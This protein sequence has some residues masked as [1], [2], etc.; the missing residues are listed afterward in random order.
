MTLRALIISYKRGKRGRGGGGR[1]GKYVS[2]LIKWRCNVC[3]ESLFILG[4]SSR[5]CA[6]SAAASI[7][8]FRATFWLICRASEFHENAYVAAGRNVIIT[9]KSISFLSQSRKN[10]ELPLCSGI[11]FALFAFF[12]FLYRDR[13]SS[14]IIENIYICERKRLY[15]A[16]R[17]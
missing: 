11:S 12:F 1:K 10:N 15:G 14:T 4:G 5:I 13:D 9:K 3:D 8:N 16:G 2:E 17:E 7:P 6:A